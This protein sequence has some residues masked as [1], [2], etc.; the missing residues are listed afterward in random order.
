M[1]KRS[2]Q[3]KQRKKSNTRGAPFVEQSMKAE[4]PKR[5]SEL[6]REF[7]I[8]ASTLA[9]VNELGAEMARLDAALR[10]CGIDPDEFGMPER[11]PV[12][13]A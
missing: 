7:F 9:L 10:E 3:P 12:P 2:Y 1:K 11:V 5:R 6:L 8:N 13:A 4:N